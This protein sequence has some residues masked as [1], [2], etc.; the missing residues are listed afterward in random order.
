MGRMA[1]IFKNRQTTYHIVGWLIFIFYEVSFVEII[2][3][4][5]VDVP[6][7]SGYIVPYLINI[8]LFYFH[9]FKTMNYCFGKA[10]K[11]PVVFI[12]LIILELFGYLLLMG[13]KDFTSINKKPNLIFFLYATNIAFIQQ[14][15]RGIY[16]LIFSTAFWLIHKSFKKE[17]QLKEA[18]TKTLLRQQEKKELELKLVSTQNAFL[19]SQINPHLLF[20]TLNFIHSEVQQ[21]STKASDAIII[22]S[23]MMRYSLAETKSDGKVGLEKEVEQIDNLIKINQFRFNNKLCINL[24]VEGELKHIRIIP[25]L[26]I[27]F[28]ENIFKYAELM[29]QTNP[30]RINIALSN[31]ILHFETFNKKRKTINFI[32][33]GIGIENVKTRLSSYY[34]EHFFLNI[35]DSDSAFSVNLIIDL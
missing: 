18:E 34:F 14:L 10:Y 8:C 24:I 26:L 16:F 19:Q 7:W 23:D 15:W 35:N 30:V 3:W 27:P 28:V 22:L 13:M 32:S 12:L 1:Y 2:R 9:A 20:N 11:R 6:I 17:Q 31:D 5:N 4:T 33:S 21:V 25:L 29:D